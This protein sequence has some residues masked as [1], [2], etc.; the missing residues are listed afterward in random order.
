M[1]IE[2]GKYVEIVYDL[3]KINPD[4]TEELVHQVDPDDPEKLIFGVMQGVVA[5]LEKALEGK[6]AGDTYDVVATADEAFGQSNP[7]YVQDLDKEIFTVDGVFD[8]EMVKPGNTLPMMTADGMR[9]FGRVLEVNPETVK[10]DF[11]HP[12]AGADVRFKGN[13]KTVREATEDELKAA[14]SGC[15]CSGG[16]SDGCQSEGDCGGGCSGCQG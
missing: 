4:G 9:I 8:E 1:K 7:D 5:P 10:L 11:N 13:V 6:E 3:Y 14:T 15:C 2:P 12:L 16:C